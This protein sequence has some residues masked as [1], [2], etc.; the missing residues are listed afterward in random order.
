MGI[1]SRLIASALD[2]CRE[3]KYETVFLWTFKGLDTARHLYDKT[4]FILTEEKPNYEWSN[5]EILEQKLELR[6]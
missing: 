5:V 3:N 4:G 2:F 6:L 1:G